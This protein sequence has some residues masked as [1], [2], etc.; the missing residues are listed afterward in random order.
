MKSNLLIFLFSAISFFAASGSCSLQFQVNQPISCHGDCNGTLQVFPT[1][2][3]P[4]T[5]VW[6]PNVSTTNL[7]TGL[8]TGIYTVQITDNTGC[9]AASSFTLTEP[10]VLSY[11]LT[12]NG[13][14]CDS[15]CNGTASVH[16]TGGSP[17]YYYLWC[18]GSTTSTASNLC[19]GNYC[20]SVSDSH[21]CSATTSF[22][23]TQP[24][25]ISAYSQLTSVPD[26]YNS[27]NG[28]AVANAIGGTSPY[29]Y[30]WC[31]GQS[32]QISTSLCVGMCCVTVTDSRGCT[33]T[34]CVTVTAPPLLSIAS[35]V[36]HNPSC[37]S[38]CDG[39][40]QATVIG[41][42][43]LLSYYWTGPNGF[44]SISQNPINL[45]AGFYTLCVTD[46]NGCT[47]CDTI[48]L[49]D[50]PSFVNEQPNN[51]GMEIYSSHNHILF[52]INGMNSSE[53]II[54]NVLGKEM[55]RKKLSDNKIE[56]EKGNLDSGVY[57]VV[58]EME[59][60]RVV[61]KFVKD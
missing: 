11:N 58:M 21:G 20:V 50:P 41:G 57:F 28:S 12:Y 3:P 25:A 14:P 29:S 10:A 34:S 53:I 56:I 55:L 51:F 4:F 23:L 5:Y 47:A 24:T 19:A 36:P 7:A 48:T 6:A 42:T 9:T 44:G 35:L 31:S 54:Y 37:I 18:N 45:C 8:C 49:Y 60:G 16:A 33:A 39:W 61:G 30:H 2:I 27:C 43:G 15:S 26:C 22:T 32:A 46:A 13:I 1:G 52:K 40:I 59:K 17:P 38:C